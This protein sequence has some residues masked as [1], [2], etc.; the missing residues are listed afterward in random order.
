MLQEGESRKILSPWFLKTSF[1]FSWERAFLT[2]D[3]IG[4]ST[5]LELQLCMLITES[6]YP[7]DN[8]VLHEL[9]IRWHYDP[10]IKKKRKKKVKAVE[11]DS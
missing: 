5:N 1:P 10:Q 3:L 4:K 11:S 7:K 8:I 9:L 2:I 6:R